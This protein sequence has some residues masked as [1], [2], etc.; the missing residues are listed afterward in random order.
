MRTN[1]VVPTASM[2]APEPTAMPMAATTH[3]VA[4]VVRPETPPLA[5]MMVPA[6]RKPT[7]V[8]IWAE[9]RPGSDIAPPMEAMVMD[10]SVSSAAPTQMRRFVRSPAGFWACWRSH[11]M[12][13]PRIAA[14]VKRRA[15]SMRN[16]GCAVWSA[17]SQSRKPA[18]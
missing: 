1:T 18:M 13:P 10:M 5:W 11:P 9:M 2:L 15:R 12:A 17:E 8:T 3:S 6:P 4:A 16:S 7:P 14:R